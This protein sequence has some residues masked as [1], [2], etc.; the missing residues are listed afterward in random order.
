MWQ[1]FELSGTSLLITGRWMLH[2]NLGNTCRVCS[3]RMWVITTDGMLGWKVLRCPPCCTWNASSGLPRC[4]CVAGDIELEERMGRLRVCSVSDVGRRIVADHYRAWR[5]NC[6]G[7]INQIVQVRR[8]LLAFQR[9]NERYGLLIALETGS[10]S[11]WCFIG[12]LCV[13]WNWQYNAHMPKRLY[14]IKGCS[15]WSTGSFSCV[16]GVV[17]G[18]WNQQRESVK[19]S[20]ARW[21]TYMCNYTWR[22]I[23]VCAVKWQYLWF[24]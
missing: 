5:R 22:V 23:N 14:K 21:A 18:E 16:F 13:I 6:T 8:Y 24:T 19:F 17:V 9:G 11:Y 7:R 10:V 15:L 4:C 12:L 1:R 2:V 20:Q 3:G